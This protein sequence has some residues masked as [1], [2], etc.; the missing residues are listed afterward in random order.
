MK[1]ILFVCTGNTCRS[2]MAEGILNKLAGERNL[3][4]FAKSAGISAA[5]GSPAS[6]NSV[7]ACEEIGVDIS[8]HRST[9]LTNQMFYEADEVV[10]LTKTHQIIMQDAFKNREKI[11][12]ALDVPDPFGGD[13]EE[14]RLCRDRIKEK[15]EEL[16][17]DSN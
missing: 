16:L 14:Y 4:V 12:P 5:E 8:G 17:D 9:Q 6:V 15:I 13:L 3:D 1:K 11:L 10:P 7:K 2:P